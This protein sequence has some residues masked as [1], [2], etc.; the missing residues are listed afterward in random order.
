MFRDCKRKHTPTEAK[1]M[2][3]SEELT[4]HIHQIKKA[5]GILSR[6][7]ELTKEEMEDLRLEI[8]IK[9]SEMERIFND[10]MNSK[11][12]EEI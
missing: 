8:R 1:V 3:K 4:F 7:E 5:I 6:E 9:L 11:I 2:T 10:W 12:K